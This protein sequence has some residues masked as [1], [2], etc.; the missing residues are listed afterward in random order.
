RVHNVAL[1][2]PAGILLISAMAPAAQFGK[3]AQH[4]EAMAA[5]VMLFKPKIGEGNQAIAGRWWH[6]HGSSNSGYGNNGTSSYVSSEKKIWLCRDGRFSRRNDF[7]ADLTT[8]T[9]QSTTSTTGNRQGGGDGRWTTMGGAQA[10][11]IIVTYDDGSREELPY[12][13]AGPGDK[14]QLYIDGTGYSR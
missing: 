5:S 6:W 11:K 1:Q 2:G 8:R 3:L 9:D 12:Q 4:T 10:G 13:V 14:W 7:N